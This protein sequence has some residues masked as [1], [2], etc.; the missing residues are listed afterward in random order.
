M[1]WSACCLSGR[2]PLGLAVLLNTCNPRTQERYAQFCAHLGCLSLYHE[3]LIPVTNR[4]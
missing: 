2:Q 1:R 4:R 3:D